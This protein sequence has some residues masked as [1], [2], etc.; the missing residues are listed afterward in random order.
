[1]IAQAAKAPLLA[2]F[3]D[4][5]GTLELRSDGA[6]RQVN[7]PH[8]DELIEFLAS[9]LAARLV[10][11]GRLIETDEISR[12]PALL[13]RHRRIAFPS[14]PWEWSPSMWASAG[15]LTLDLCARLVK[16]GWILKDA[17]PLN[18]LFEGVDPVFVDVLSVCRADLRRPIW[19]AYGQFVRTF[20]LPMLAYG[21]MGWPLQAAMTRRDGYE[22]EEIW[23]ALPWSTR[24]RAPALGAVTLPVF[25][26]RKRTQ[27]V[28]TPESA[29]G[30]TTEPEATRYILGK[31]LK[32]LKEWMEKSTPKPAASTWT[33]YT[34]TATHYSGEDHSGKR[35]FVRDVL[36]LLRPER[37]LD[38]GCNTG[39]YSKL[40]AEAGADVVS[41][42]TDLQTVDRL[43]RSLVGGPLARSILPLCVDISRPSPAVGW[44][45]RENA[46]FLERCAGQFDL[47]M[48][49]AVI[50]HLLLRS[51]VP[52][53]LI[54]S[55]CTQLTTRDLIIEWVPPSDIRFR[56]LLHGRGCDLHAPH[57][58]GV[59]G[60][61]CDAL[62]CGKGEDPRE[63]PNAFPCASP[64]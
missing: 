41:V 37:V 53:P 14:F 44:E 48:M 57:R 55:L 26:S 25:L 52:L 24:V 31:T 15:N 59:P 1:M 49:L 11:E 39:V 4:P 62:R 29:G 20:V 58:G 16:E 46:S 30:G 51:Q 17:T 60:C 56:E 61:L 7:A 10:A 18:V 2:T 6:Y 33:E 21:A 22:P 5:A 54:A 36:D 34:E 64:R 40:A 50:H 27:R 63:R 13:L 19:Y 32:R 43:C 45:N 42:D 9:P 38:V 35:S 28:G 12:T 3:R 47:V 8:D 23:A